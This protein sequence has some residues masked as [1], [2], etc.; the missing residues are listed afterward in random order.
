[1]RDG[2]AR[3]PAKTTICR[4]V[5]START[6]SPSSAG[7]AALWS[8]DALAVASGSLVDVLV[9]SPTHV[10]TPH[11]HTLSTGPSEPALHSHALFHKI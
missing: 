1:M 7:S 5:L 11:A 3:K 9:R 2:Y 4:S 8:V 6:G 10:T